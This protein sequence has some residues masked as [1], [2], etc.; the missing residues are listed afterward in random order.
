MY[1]IGSPKKKLFTFRKR[2]TRRVLALTQMA[3]AMLSLNA[4]WMSQLRTCCSLSSLTLHLLML[5]LV[6]VYRLQVS[7]DHSM[8]WS[9]SGGDKS[10][11]SFVH[12]LK[13]VSKTEHCSFLYLPGK[14]SW[15]LFKLTVSLDGVERM[16][17]RLETRRPIPESIP[18][19]CITA[20][21]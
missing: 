20:R 13:H 1:K 4:R 21:Y 18:W 16:P 11:V 19:P 14:S 12:H 2:N 6:S 5:E 15:Q 17:K 3:S 7:A 10:L 9:Y 8:L